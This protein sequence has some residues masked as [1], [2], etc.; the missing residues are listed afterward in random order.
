MNINNLV[1]KYYLSNDFNMLAIKTK[2]DYQYC[3]GILLAT[4]V[5]IWQI[6]YVL[7]LGKFIHSLWR[8]VMQRVTHSLPLSVRLLNLEM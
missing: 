6:I 7:P 1:D 2:V 3:S 8:W 4:K 5:D